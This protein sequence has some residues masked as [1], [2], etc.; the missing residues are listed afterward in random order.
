PSI[1]SSPAGIITVVIVPP[2]RASGGQPL[3]AGLIRLRKLDHGRIRKPSVIL[4]PHADCLVVRSCIEFNLEISRNVRVAIRGQI[5]DVSEWRHR[6]QLAG[7]KRVA[8]LRFGCEAQLATSN[9]FPQ[10]VQICRVLRGEDSNDEL[11]L[12]CL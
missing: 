7:W 6:A 11:I 8:K 12:V 4:E 2:S 1:D 3:N 10:S 9:L 5:E